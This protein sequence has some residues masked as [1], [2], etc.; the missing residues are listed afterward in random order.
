MKKIYIYLNPC[1]SNRFKIK[2]IISMKFFLISVLSLFFFNLSF[3]QNEIRISYNQSIHLT[4]VKNDTDF[5]ITGTQLKVHLKGSQINRYLFEKPGEYNIR[6]KEHIKSKTAS[7]EHSDEQKDITVI[8]S[9]IRMAF[10]ANNIAFSEPIRKNVE[11]SKITVSVPVKIETYDSKPALL[12]FTPVNT[13]G[14]GTN[15]VASLDRNSSELPEGTH[16][17]KYHLKGIITE[18]SY[19]M[20]DFVDANKT[21]QSV[22]L[23]TPIKD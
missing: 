2:Y 18:N 8:V 20:F 14:I 12:D 9:R 19:L 3:S 4:K 21:V 16:I 1:L 11:T 13:A 17:L 6:I 7:C 15:I 22:A 10:D 5:Y 23:L